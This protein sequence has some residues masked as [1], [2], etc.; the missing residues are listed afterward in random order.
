MYGTLIS[1][2]QKWPQGV[3]LKI[4]YFRASHAVYLPPP[5][6]KILSPHLGWPWDPPKK[7]G[8]DWSR[9]TNFKKICYSGIVLNLDIPADPLPQNW[10]D[11]RTHQKKFG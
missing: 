3:P 1:L 4:Q 7:F 8:E 6:L 9:N 11:P 2:K 10:V 5:L